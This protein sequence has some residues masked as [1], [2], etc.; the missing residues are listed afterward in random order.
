MLHTAPAV[1]TPAHLLQGVA[2]FW[3]KMFSFKT[4]D[5]FAS[6]CLTRVFIQHTGLVSSPEHG[7]VQVISTRCL[8]CC[9]PV[10]SPAPARF[11]P[12]SIRHST[13]FTT[14]N[15]AGAVRY[16]Q[17]HIGKSPN[18]DPTSLPVTEVMSPPKKI[19]VANHP[20]CGPFSL[21]LYFILSACPQASLPCVF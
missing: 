9:L 13:H 1:F 15:T 4:D 19:K 21:C 11:L 5:P 3:A 2:A 6:N 7:I 14:A 20:V 16:I 12:R 17:R 18:E 10:L 8:I